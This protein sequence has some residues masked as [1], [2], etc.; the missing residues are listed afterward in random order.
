M[1]TSPVFSAAAWQPR[2]RSTAYPS[3]TRTLLQTR[4]LLVWLCVKLGLITVEQRRA[5]MEA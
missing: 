1:L 2:R 4:D 5:P 3:F